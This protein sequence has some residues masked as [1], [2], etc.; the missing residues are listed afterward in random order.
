M[1]RLEDFKPIPGLE[2]YLIN[3]NG[4]VY[5]TRS[6][7]LLSPH[8]SSRGYLKFTAY[9]NGKAVNKNI[10]RALMETFIKNEGN[11]PCVNH[12][13]GNKTN[14]NLEN[15]EWCSYS[16]NI[17]HAYKN[18]LINHDKVKNNLALQRQKMTKEIHCKK[19]IK[20]RKKVICQKTGIIYESVLAAPKELGI[21]DAHLS[22]MLNGVR[23][24]NTNLRFL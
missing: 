10:H 16:H 14:N 22:R 17:S 15:L 21:R 1:L 20:S 11:L 7:R 5:S 24:N 23:K 13:D 18:D 6:K 19:G 8:I 2:R 3:T 12:K 9:L 4:D